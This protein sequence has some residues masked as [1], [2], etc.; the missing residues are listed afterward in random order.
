MSFTFA[1]AGACAGE[2]G[3][4]LAVLNVRG[5]VHKV[6]FRFNLFHAVVP[7]VLYFELS[8]ERFHLERAFTPFFLPGAYVDAVVENVDSLNEA[9]AFE[10]SAR[11]VPLAEGAAAVSPR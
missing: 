6:L 9:H 4:E 8:F 3:N 2:F 11:I 1:T 5:N 10:L 7:V